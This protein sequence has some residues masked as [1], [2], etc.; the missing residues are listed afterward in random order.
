MKKLKRTLIFFIFGFI[1]LFYSSK[2][3]ALETGFFPP[4]TCSTN[5]S[6]CSAMNLQ[7]TNYNSWVGGKN[8][9]IKVTFGGVNVPQ[10]AV[11]EDIQIKMR[12]RTGISGM[13]W[14][15]S[16]SDNLGATY[17]SPYFCF[18]YSPSSCQYNTFTSFNPIFSPTFTWINTNHTK[19]VTG[20]MINDPNFILRIYH[21]NSFTSVNTDIDTLLFNVRYHFPDPNPTPTPQPGVTPYL[22][23]SGFTALP[24]YVTGGFFYDSINIPGYVTGEKLMLSSK[25]DGTGDVQVADIIIATNIGIYFTYNAISFCSLPPI[26]LPPTNLS[27]YLTTS[28]PY[29]NIKLWDT[30]LRNKTIGPMYLVHIKNVPTPTPT[31]TPTLNPHAPFLDL[32]WDYEG[33]GLT[34][35]EAALSM[36]SYFDHSLPVLG[37]G[38]SEPSDYI[39]QI[40][41]F[42]NELSTTKNY[43]SHDGYDY[44]KSAKVNIGDS[45]LAAAAG[46]ATYVNSCVPCGNMIVIDHGNGYQTRYLHM[47]KNGLVTSIPGVP[48][49]VNALQIIGKVGATGNV[50][51]S[52]DAGAHIH[53]GVFED[54]NHDGNFGDNI[55][56]GVTDPFGWQSKEPDPWEIYSFTYG[57]SARTGNKSYYLWK[58]KLDSKND[59]LNTSG[60]TFTNS[61]TTIS[62]QE[63][64]VLANSS[65]NI[66]SEP[67]VAP[68]ATL[69]SIGPAFSVTATDIIGNIITQFLKPFTI[70]IDFSK[71]DLTR[72]D[73]NTISLYSSI[74]GKVWTKETTAVDLTNKISTSTLNHLTHF[75]LLAERKDEQSS[76]TTVQLTGDK[77]V[78]SWYRSDVLVELTAVDNEGGLGVD[79]IMYRLDDGDWEQYNTSIVASTEGHHQVEF[80]SADNDENF[81]TV[82]TVSF[83]ID[84]TLPEI[85]STVTTNGGTY[86]SNTWVNTDVAV[87]FSCTDVLSGVEKVSDPILFSEDGQNQLATGECED[88]AGNKATVS[89]GGINIDK[90]SPVITINATPQVLWPPNGKMIKLNITGRVEDISAVSKTFM[91][92]DEYGLIAPKLTDFDQFIQ[93]EAKRNGSDLDGRV[94]I[95]KV[96]A[97]DAAGNTAENEVHVIVPHDQKN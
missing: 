95:I 77:G 10:D 55:P 61:N 84:K 79:Y 86:V 16:F 48:I 60:G 26:P 45:V 39:N 62:F 88:K 17:Y 15:T 1:Y 43:S 58:K 54:K 2:S 74:D 34:F 47:Q 11:I 46:I 67:I 35:T 37:A 92:E 91:V 69:S 28:S 63:D 81:E 73:T 7:D 13:S 44:A 85:S 76:T 18:P 50:S 68:S 57:G 20:A 49:H 52:G 56:D 78:E 14:S 12:I 80:Y 70:Q 36:S 59:T 42:K 23:T 22:I 83:D 75:A 4:T 40:T 21:V 9:E 8:E 31:P 29:L 93:L 38:M 89:V 71:W 25:P 97:T 96:Q 87:L 65:L 24:G 6:S 27:P 72:Y 64:S 33:Q 66:Q 41:T 82:K 5:G 53:F 51:P 32:P 30:C 19:K 90:I 94:Y 3:Y